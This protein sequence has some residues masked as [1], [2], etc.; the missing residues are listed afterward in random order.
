MNN[1]KQNKMRIFNGLKCLPV[2]FL[3]LP[4]ADT[5]NKSRDCDILF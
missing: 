3:V 5:N 4:S 1:K 2:T